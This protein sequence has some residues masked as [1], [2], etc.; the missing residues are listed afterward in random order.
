M[1]KDASNTAESSEKNPFMFP[2]G[3]VTLLTTHPKTKQ[4]LT[5]TVVSY[6][7]TLA[8]PVWKKFLFPPWETNDLESKPK[9]IDCTEDDSSA[10]LILLNIAHLR[11]NEVPN[12]KLEYSLLFEVAKLCDQ[13]DCVNLVRP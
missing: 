5:G 12:G 3:D 9:Q 4:P 10:L 2:S 8:S 11:F 13:Y 7:L 1:A 6:A